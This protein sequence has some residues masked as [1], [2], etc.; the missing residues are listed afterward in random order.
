LSGSTYTTTYNSGLT[1]YSSRWIPPFIGTVTSLSISYGTIIDNNGSV[2]VRVLIGDNY[3]SSVLYSYNTNYNDNSVSLRTFTP[4][5]VTSNLY[6]NRYDGLL[7]PRSSNTS[8]YIQIQ[9]I[10]PF[11]GRVQ[12]TVMLTNNE[13]LYNLVFQ[14]STSYTY[15]LAV[16]SAPTITTSNYYGSATINFTAVSNA[17]SYVAYAYTDNIFTRNTP[18]VISSEIV[19]STVNSSII[20]SGLKINTN[21]YA[22][23][24]AY[25]GTNLT[26]NYS[27]Q[28]NYSNVFTANNIL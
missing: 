18:G 20:M 9:S 4:N 10:S 15:E 28:S 14:P 7:Y 11:G 12:A 17:N 27:S 26:G 3:S 16:P 13:L 19:N 24:I 5:L 25:T 22:I 2:V 6:V 21:Y 8:Y 1:G 23:I